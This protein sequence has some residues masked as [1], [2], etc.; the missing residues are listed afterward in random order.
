MIVIDVTARVSKI[1]GPLKRVTDL[2]TK[3]EKSID[4]AAQAMDRLAAAA[5]KAGAVN[6]MMPAVP[7]VRPSGGGTGQGR[8]PKP[9][10]GPSML[11]L[12]RYING[13]NTAS[14]GK[15]QPQR[16][17]ALAHTFAHYQTLA[18]QGNPHAMRAVSSLA[19]AVARMMK[20]PKGFRQL[21]MD[22]LM[23]SRFGMGAGGV[24]MM[25][26][27]GR[28][29]AAIS[30]LGPAGIAAAGGLGLLAA[31]IG[32]V[33]N[34][35]MA[36][37]NSA[38]KMAG[39]GTT[40]GTQAI[41]D[42]LSGVLG[43]DASQ[44]AQQFGG[45]ISHGIG[46]GFAAR[47]GIQTY[48]GAYGD[49]DVGAKFAKYANYVG[50]SKS[51]REAQQKAIGVGMP[52]LANMYYLSAENKKDLASRASQGYSQQD[53]TTS[54]N[55][56]YA[57]N[58]LKDSFEKLINK[59]AIRF[60][61]MLI[62]IMDGIGNMLDWLGKA[63]DAVPDVVKRMMMGAAGLAGSGSVDSTNKK[64]AEADDRN[65][66]ALNENTRALKDYREIM[67]GG[68]RA[69]SAIPK[70]ISGMRLGDPSYRIG[71]EGGIA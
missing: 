37:N 57:I 23:T 60:G 4:K 18:S 16:N 14:G 38:L 45:N 20:P 54:V 49:F 63:W 47:A 25:P 52:Q 61:P 21:A 2:V 44:M 12:Y 8:Q 39:A 24:S 58:K 62:K 59:I 32:T 31:A 10:A 53:V 35:I 50:N 56:A 7:S 68:D 33:V 70:R 43:G 40:P 51:Y 65:I 46:A 29:V 36:I 34:S 69:N 15:L 64:M 71:L 30:K 41:L 3:M 22:A 55:G 28:T 1:E 5:A 42:R 27:I 66:R 19:P 11:D 13:L 67:G 26:L 6:P 17:Q 9:A 48:S